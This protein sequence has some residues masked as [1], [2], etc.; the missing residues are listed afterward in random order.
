MSR[1]SVLVVAV[2]A[3]VLAL[4]PQESILGLVGNAWAGFGA[5][6]GPLVILSLLWKRITA[7]GALS[8]MVAGGATVLL[9]VYLPHDYKAVYRSEERRVGNECVQT[10]RSR[11]WQYH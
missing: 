5:A 9:W 11:W 6:F 3:F 1:I 10:C 2:V 8:G 4:N 7:A